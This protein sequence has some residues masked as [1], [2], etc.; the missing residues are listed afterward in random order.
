MRHND[1][2]TNAEREAAEIAELYATHKARG[3]LGTFY[4]LYYENA[5]LEYQYPPP[6]QREDGGRER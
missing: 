5:P 6:P 3:S 1:F 4:Y 2:L